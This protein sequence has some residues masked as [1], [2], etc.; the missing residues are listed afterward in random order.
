ME[1]YIKTQRLYMK[2]A[3]QTKLPGMAVMKFA[4]LVNE[5]A[6]GMQVL[7]SIRETMYLDTTVHE[8]PYAPLL[9]EHDVQALDRMARASL[10]MLTNESVQLM[11]WAYDH[12]TTEGVE[13][14]RLH[15]QQ[16]PKGG[17]A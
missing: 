14:R 11:D 5:V 7:F 6:S 15:R 2:A 8:Q 1:P 17:G 12:H 9:S 4:E 13:R 10:E 3:E 16:M